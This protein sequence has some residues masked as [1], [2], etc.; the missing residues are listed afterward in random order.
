[1][2]LIPLKELHIGEQDES[3]WQKIVGFYPVW[4]AGA[5]ES[6]N[7][8]IEPNMTNLTILVLRC[9]IFFTC[10]LTLQIFQSEM[11]KKFSYKHVS[12]ILHFSTIKAQM[13]ALEKNNSK[14]KKIVKIA[15]QKTEMD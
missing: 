15:M 8:I 5:D 7:V 1:M 13:L 14:I 4:F 10:L 12:W 2:Y 9:L 3:S 6:G 11:F